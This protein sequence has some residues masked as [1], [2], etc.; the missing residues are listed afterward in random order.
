LPAAVQVW[1][2]LLTS[3]PPLSP[4]LSPLGSVLLDFVLACYPAPL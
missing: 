1:L 3:R 4:A 2:F